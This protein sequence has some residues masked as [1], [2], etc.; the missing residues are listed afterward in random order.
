MMRKIEKITIILA[1][2]FFFSYCST[3]IYCKTLHPTL[4]AKE[5][6]MLPNIVPG[7]IIF[8]V[9]SEEIKKGDILIFTTENLSAFGLKQPIKVSHR[10]IDI[11][12]NTYYLTKGD[13]ND[14]PDP[15][16]I[17]ESNVI[18][19]V[20]IKISKGSYY[21]F[22]FYIVMLVLIYISFF[23]KEKEWQKKVI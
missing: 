20:W 8:I 1:F 5:E 19:I 16:L 12:N 2:T 13:N 9:K 17:P 14:Y 10:V 15:Q 21:L 11:I 4:I 23:K 22:S 18:G 6:S 7:D 3:S